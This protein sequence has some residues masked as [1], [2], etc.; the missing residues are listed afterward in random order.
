M[1][2]TSTDGS[3][4]VGQ[5]GLNDSEHPYNIT[6]QFIQQALGDVGT[7]KLVKV[8]SVREVTGLAPVGFVDVQILV[9][10]VDGLLGS[11]TP[12]GTTYHLPYMRLQGG[13][14]AIIC[15]PVV[16]DI[17]FAV[18]CDR[19]ISA[20]KNTKAA[21]NPSTSRRFSISDG[22]Y[23]GGVLNGTP[24]QYIQFTTSGISIV[25]ANGNKLVSS[26]TGWAFTGLVQMNSGMQL[27]GNI[28]AIGG[29]TYAGNFITT[30]TIQS[31]TISLQAHHHLAP[32]GG[33]NTGPALT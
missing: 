30:G 18:I 23:V 6:D 11:S 20:V 1:T 16:G 33:G 3:G 4:V 2:D 31:G 28:G 8:M 10:L 14:N 24:N 13:K 25:D 29:G 21:A 5:Q 7:V 9:N 15:D 26:P 22:I 32:S 17:G 19:D 27:S 12:H